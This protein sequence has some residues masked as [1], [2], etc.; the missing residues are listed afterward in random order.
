MKINQLTVVL[1]EFASLYQ[2]AGGTAEAVGLRRLAAAL[3]QHGQ[4]DAKEIPVIIAGRSAAKLE[5]QR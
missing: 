2:S 5:Q 1:R 3:K 4:K